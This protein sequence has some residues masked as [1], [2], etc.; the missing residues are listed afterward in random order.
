[1]SSHCLGSWND[2][3]TISIGRP[4]SS[5]GS[6]LRKQLEEIRLN[7][8]RRA[9]NWMDSV[10]AELEEVLEECSSDNWDGYGAPIV[11][12]AAITMARITARALNQMVRSSVPAPDVVPEVDGDISRSW[13]RD[14]GRG[15]SLS[16]SDH[17]TLSFAGTIAKGIERHGT[18]TFDGMDSGSLR[19]IAGYLERLYA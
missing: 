14:H 12:E 16:V 17:H 4:A 1:M 6:N 11:K 15:F 18:E 5:T 13:T 3:N 7:S 9:S 19:E 8:R 10:D 2:F